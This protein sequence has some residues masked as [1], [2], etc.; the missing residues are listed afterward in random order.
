LIWFP[1]LETKYY[2]GVCNPST[3]RLA[4]PNLRLYF[5]LISI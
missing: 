1:F 5:L 2:R 3:P 4:S